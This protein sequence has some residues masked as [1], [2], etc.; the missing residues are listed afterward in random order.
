MASLKK[1]DAPVTVSF[2]GPVSSY[3]HQVHTLAQ[4]ERPAWS[5]GLTDLDIAQAALDAFD[6]GRYD[7]QPAVT[8]T[9]I[10]DAVQSGESTFGVVPFE[11]STNGA[12]VYTFEL[13]ADRHS[14][15][16]DV[17]VC[18]EAY[19]DVS[20]CLVGTNCESIDSPDISGTCTPTISTPSPLKPRVSPLHSVKH[21]KRLLSHPQAFGQ[22]DVFLNFYMKGV[23]RIDVSSTSR[24]A[25][26]AKED[27]TGA[28]AAIASIL[29]AEVQGID[30][31]A[32]GIEDREDNTTR[33]L[34]LRKGSDS[35]A[36]SADET[37]S[38][39]SFKIDHS[40]PGAL[41]SVLNCFQ[42]YGINLTSINSRPTKVVPFQ[43]IFFV[44]FEGSRLHDPS[45]MVTK[46]LDALEDFVQSW[47]WL[48]TPWHL[49][50]ATLAEFLP[51]SCYPPV[52]NPSDLVASYD[53]ASN[54]KQGVVLPQGYH[55]VY[56][57]PAVLSSGLLPDGTDSLH[58]PGPP[59]VRR[60]WA[61][62]SLTFNLS[63]KRQLQVT[64]RLASCAED[65]THLHIKGTEGD[66]KVFV[67]T[68]R[69]IGVDPGRDVKCGPRKRR[70]AALREMLGDTSDNDNVNMGMLSL[71]ET[72]QLV[73][74][75]EKS[76]EEA[77]EDLKKVSK[78]IKPIHTP[79]FSVSITP[80]P[81]LI[82]RFSALTFNAH[83][84][85]L[86]RQY[87]RD[88]EGYR[89]LLVQGPLSLVLMF[90]VMRSQLKQGE[91]V[92]QFKYRNLAPLYAEEEMKICVR[93][94]PE[95][96]ERLDV[97]IVGRD[98]GYAVKG[99]AVVGPT[100][101]WTQRES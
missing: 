1:E 80:T 79:D 93:R 7:Y 15:Y 14:R 66:E 100:K 69:Q 26:L 45:G 57:P 24:A 81:A 2:L 62:G 29:A 86:D 27:T 48:A 21:I 56:F 31:L 6:S 75:R 50:N 35:N 23:E 39:I 19:L 12:V 9:D 16:L 11:N 63:E 10:F 5:I 101:S 13:L 44:E 22:C 46:T 94:D 65:I 61:G 89:N 96:K 67:S 17:T 70:K 25:E 82:F 87:A 68:R 33:F 51:Q 38:L 99:T 58:S 32:K 52:F 37:K 18:G 84:I 55:L 97:W 73:F 72:R 54:R 74:M 41:A 78:V 3:T 76:R 43:Y 92:A 59:F 71:L 34:I 30:V 42:K 98:G 95:K 53:F 77:S 85:H 91:I 36:G 88:V 90:S 83:A 40:T 8:I 47:R 20:H 4:A 64:G 49:L 60:L 28:S